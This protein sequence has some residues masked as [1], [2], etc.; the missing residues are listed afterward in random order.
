MNTFWK[1]S[2]TLFLVLLL[3]SISL[4]LWLYVTN[5]V[6]IQPDH[7]HSEFRPLFPG[8]NYTVQ[9]PD[10]E[11]YLSSMFLF[12]KS[13]PEMNEYELVAISRYGCNSYTS[14]PISDTDIDLKP[15]IDQPI[16]IREFTNT[17]NGLELNE[18]DIDNQVLTHLDEYKKACPTSFSKI[19]S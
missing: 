10:L 19:E 18:I 3:A 2:S 5:Y 6:D 16:L 9:G 8:I 11:Q 17:E 12:L 15:Y 1:K 4:N 13:D 14:F 7:P